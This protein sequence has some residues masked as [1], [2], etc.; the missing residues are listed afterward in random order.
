MKE[1]Y[2]KPALF[3]ERFSLTQNIASGCGPIDSSLGQ[4]GPTD[5]TTCGWWEVGGVVKIFTND[6]SGC[7]QKAEG[8]D[9]VNGVCFNAPTSS[10]VIY[11]AM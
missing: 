2:V 8:Y 9:D 4:P 5:K 3:I 1:T 7:A 11:N 10:N 6:I